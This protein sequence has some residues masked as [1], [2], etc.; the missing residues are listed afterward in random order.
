[1]DK[2]KPGTPCEKKPKAGDAIFFCFGQEILD[3]AP[4]SAWERCAVVCAGSYHEYK[5]KTGTDL[6]WEHRP[7]I[8]EPNFLYFERLR[9]GLTT[10]CIFCKRDGSDINPRVRVCPEPLTNAEMLQT[11]QRA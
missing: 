8:D 5:R 2:T 6:Y 4:T 11:M 9:D 10:L 7:P 3:N 1:M